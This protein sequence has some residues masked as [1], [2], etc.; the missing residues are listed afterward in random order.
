MLWML[1][2]AG[3]SVVSACFATESDD[4]L[5]SLNPRG[6]V[7]DYAGVLS[8]S[9]GTSLES[10]IRSYEQQTGNEIGV[11]VIDSLKGGDIDDF[12]NKL[13]AKWGVGKKDKDNGVL[14]LVSIQ[15]RA[16]RIEVGYELE[17]KLTDALAGRI[18][19]EQMFPSFKQGR[20][21]EGIALAV[22]GI[23]SIAKGEQ[24]GNSD[25]E[26]TSGPGNKMAEGVAALNLPFWVPLIV[27]ATLTFLMGGGI[28]A[29]KV[30]LIFQSAAL[31]IMAGL[32]FG[33]IGIAWL[34][35]GQLMG[36][37]VAAIISLVI[38]FFLGRGFPKFFER[39]ENAM[40]RSGSRSSRGGWS[41]GGGSSRGGFGGGRSGGGGASGRW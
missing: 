22:G 14:L 1:L 30:G 23:I 20:Y 15:D 5:A 38:S 26:A 24:Q 18:L 41:S 13:F 29:K 35:T 19:R 3:L 40:E 12:A 11:A 16:A 39:I 27:A 31:S 25:V 33:N 6:M 34:N 37:F 21:G 36:I 2:A 7:S 9:D 8:Q 28:G 10:A 4:L 32:I 17:P